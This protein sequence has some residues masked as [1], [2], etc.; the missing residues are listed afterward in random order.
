MLLVRPV[1]YRDESLESFV[2][3]VSIDNGFSS[4]DDL[5]RGIGKALFNKA[6]DRRLQFPIQLSALNLLRSKHNSYTRVQYLKSLS[7][8]TFNDSTS[9]LQLVIYRGANDFSKNVKSVLMQGISIP[10]MFL[11]TEGIPVCP[12][13]LNEK[14]YIRQLWHFSPY[15]HCHIHKTKL[16]SHCECGHQLNYIKDES[17]D[18]CSKCK[19]SLAEADVDVESDIGAVDIS[20]WL[21]GEKINQFPDISISHRWG[22]ILWFQ[23]YWQRRVRQDNVSLGE[24]LSDWPTRFYHYLNEQVEASLCYALKPQ[25]E[26]NFKDVFHTLL[27]DSSYLPTRELSNNIVLQALKSY[28]EVSLESNPEFFS[29]LKLNSIEVACLL[30]ISVEQVASLVGQGELRSSIRLKADKALNVIAPAFYLGDVFLLWLVSFQTDLS[31]RH[32]YASK[33]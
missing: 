26:L 29:Y 21:A 5:L 1:P 32:I 7:Q 6:Q 2:L 8:L 17:I 3:R 27:I 23:Q 11:R 31:G 4:P 24:L 22:M 28:L 9:L 15:T 33:W 20:T 19:Q 14:S 25:Q 30:G 13:C 12:H 10:R 16:V 18:S